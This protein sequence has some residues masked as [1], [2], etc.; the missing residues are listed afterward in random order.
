MKHLAVDPVFNADKARRLNDMS[1]LETQ[2]S[3]EALARLLG[4][5]GN[6]DVAD[7]GSGTGFY[8]D[9]VAGLTSGLVY[10]VEFQSKM[11]AAYRERGVPANVR[12]VEADLRDIPLPE[13]SIDAVYS[14]AVFHEAKGDL[15]LPSLL[16]LLR[17][18]GRLVIID[19]RSD[20][21][22]W[23]SGP[24]AALRF[25]KDTVAAS[26]R[27]YFRCVSAENVGRFMFAVVAADLV[28]EG[29]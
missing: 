9:I 7:L 28:M 25:D 29:R 26:L 20:P 21:E 6:E 3:Q 22:S 18:P 27:P 10:A 2:V 19:W 5:T 12:L 16:P 14:I 4:L 24:P 1:R 8:T 15:G 11:N 23:E 13:G 17:P